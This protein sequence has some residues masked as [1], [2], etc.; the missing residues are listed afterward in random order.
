MAGCAK[1]D[2]C[3]KNPQNL[4]YKAEKKAEV[5]K[6]KHVKQAA[7]K[8][9]KDATKVR[10]VARGTARA[11]KRAAWQ[12]RSPDHPYKDYVHVA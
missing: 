5:H 8:A 10:K 12:D 2:R 7:A 1:A 3:R 6:A 9:A 4:R 11:L